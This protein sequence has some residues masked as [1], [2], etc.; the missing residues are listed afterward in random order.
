MKYLILCLMFICSTSFAQINAKP[1]Y[2]TKGLANTSSELQ[3]S[4]NIA[5]DRSTF[6]GR[7]ALSSDQAAKIDGAITKSETTSESEIKP[8]S[9]EAKLIEL[10]SMLDKGLINKQDYEIKKQ[11]ILKTL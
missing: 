2:N 5:I 10:K 6:S 3:G 4:S 11:Q 8:S 9:A 1:Q 7:G